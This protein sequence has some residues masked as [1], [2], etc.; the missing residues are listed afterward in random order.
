[1]QTRALRPAASRMPRALESERRVDPVRAA[2]TCC[3]SYRVPHLAGGPSELEP[4]PKL[5]R[6]RPAEL[7]ER[8][9]SSASN[10]GGAEARGQCPCGLAEQATVQR[11]HRRAETDLIE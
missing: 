8:T 7:I 4:Q 6:T 3:E 9:E 1:M 10:A 2:A 5:N 11:I